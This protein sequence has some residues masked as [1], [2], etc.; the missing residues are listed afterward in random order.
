[1]AVMWLFYALLFM[2]FSAYINR[3]CTVDF[4]LPLQCSN[5]MAISLYFYLL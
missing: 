4:Y 1:M 5:L 2:H 3:D